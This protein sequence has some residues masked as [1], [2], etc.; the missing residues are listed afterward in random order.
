MNWKI[1]SLV[2]NR[3]HYISSLTSYTPWIS[4]TCLSLRNG[5]RKG[6]SIGVSNKVVAWYESLRNVSSCPLKDRAAV[7]SWVELVA[8]R[9]HGSC[10]WPRQKKGLIE[11]ANARDFGRIYLKWTVLQERMMRQRHLSFAI[12]N[13]IVTIG[14]FNG[15]TIFIDPWP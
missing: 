1:F 10:D 2:I 8:A 14:F 3:H 7:G 5:I 13:N 15:R 9:L 12:P 6:R 11:W 4:G